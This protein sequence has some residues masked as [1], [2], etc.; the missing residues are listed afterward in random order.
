VVGELQRVGIKA[1]IQ[2]GKVVVLEDCPILKRGDVITKEVSSALARFGIMPLELGLRLRAAYEDGILFT[3]EVLEVD[4]AVV[5]AQLQEAGLNALNLAL[6]VNYPTSLTISLMIARADA[7]AW[8]L[9]LEACV[10]V[11]H[12]VPALLAR[13]YA[14]MLALATVLYARDPNALDGKLRAIL[15]VP[16]PAGAGS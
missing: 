11:P 10:P 6:N 4:E 14:E 13:S 12:V 8:N 1:R 15:G 2:A 16:K 3:G 7:N 5:L 9:A